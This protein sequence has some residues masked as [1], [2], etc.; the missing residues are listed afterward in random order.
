[1]LHVMICKVKGYADCAVALP[2]GQEASMMNAQGPVGILVV[3]GSHAG[4]PRS[5]G[6]FIDALVK[7]NKEQISG[8]C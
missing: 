1:M 8:V 3:D 4:Y 6:L 5:P 2:S 7:E